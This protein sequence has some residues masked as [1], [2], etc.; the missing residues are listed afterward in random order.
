MKTAINIK[1]T[2]LQGAGFLMLSTIIVNAGNYGINL[3]LGRTLG[4]SLFSEANVLASLVMMLS[5]IGV[6]IQLTAAK[7]SA[8]YF[9]TNNQKDLDAFKK[10]FIQKISKLGKRTLVALLVLTP[11]IQSYV[12]FESY[13]P[14]LILFLGVPS[15]FNFSAWRGVLQGTDQFDKMAWS[16]IIEMIVRAI[17]TIL[18]VVVAS[19]LASAVVA[20]AFMASFVVG[21]LTIKENTSGKIK[22]ELPL[23]GMNKFLLVIGAYELSQILINH[24]DVFLAKHYFTAFEAGIYSSI[25]L[26][27]K[28]VF[29]STWVIV[30]LMFPKVIEM[31]KRGEDHRPLFTQA[32]SIVALVG[33]LLTTVS[34]FL[35]TPISQMA[36]GD[37]FVSGA[38]LLWKYCMATCLFS[39]ANVFAY[40]HMSLKN[41][42]PVAISILFGIIQIG[43]INAYHSSLHQMIEVQIISMGALLLGMCLYHTLYRRVNLRKPFFTPTFN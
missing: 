23:E 17:L 34:Y 43:L 27:G 5:F 26:L 20:F 24:S 14:L 4:P 13:L 6:G 19:N 36:F 15:Y 40:Y 2:F 31:Q 35:A 25:S 41:Y 39:L 7:F 21:N 16:Y 11:V 42:F 9:A 22:N 12:R 28:I 1:S 3:I 8:E 38:P 37:A 10:I 30:S 32:F 18:V 33:I 29:F